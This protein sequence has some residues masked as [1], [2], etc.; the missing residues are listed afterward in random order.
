MALVSLINISNNPT[1][2][3]KRNLDIIGLNIGSTRIDMTVVIYSLDSNS[4]RLN[5]LSIPAVN[6]VDSATDDTL[7]DP[8]TGVYVI[9][10]GSGGYNYL[11]GPS[12]GQ[13][14]TGTPIGEYDFLIAL[15][16]TSVNISTLMTSYIALNDSLGYYN[17]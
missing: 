12:N 8:A 10:N 17:I 11:G 14:F 5:T 3:L 4:N 7:I 9:S 6:F 15:L 2:G 13:P 16:N 1:T